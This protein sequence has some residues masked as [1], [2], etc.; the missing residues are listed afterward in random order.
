MND[1][2]LVSEHSLHDAAFELWI[3]RYKLAQQEPP[4]PC[5]RRWK[6]IDRLLENILGIGWTIERRRKSI[7]RSIKNADNGST[8]RRMKARFP[9]VPDDELKIAIRS[10][11]KLDSDLARNFCHSE[12]GLSNNVELAVAQARAANPG[13][14]EA[15]YCRAK[16]WLAF[17]TRSAV[18]L[19]PGRA[20]ERYGWPLPPA[21]P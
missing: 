14:S 11:I 15:S 18:T 3:N 10:A 12:D 8:F 20:A 17:Q 13:F 16:Q 9:D 6:A 7:A 21:A 5:K 1:P 19:R 2:A 4:P